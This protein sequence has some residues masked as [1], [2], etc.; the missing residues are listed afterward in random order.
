MNTIIF[1]TITIG[2]V[3]TTSKALWT[4]PKIQLAAAINLKA[5]VNS[6]IKNYCPNLNYAQIFSCTL[7]MEC[8]GTFILLVCPDSSLDT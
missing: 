5:S 2:P 8:N 1:I 7:S 4:L 6:D 3:S